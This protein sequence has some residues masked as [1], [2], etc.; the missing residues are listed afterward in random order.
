MAMLRR[1]SC[2]A[3]ALLLAAPAGA[4]DQSSQQV[5]RLLD[6]ATQSYAPKGYRPDSTSRSGALREGATERV[7]FHLSGGGI[8]SIIGVCDTSCS[9]L[10][11]VLYDAAGHVVDKDVLDD[12]APIVSWTGAS[13][14][15][16]VEVEMVKCAMSSCRYGLR[17]F[18]KP[19]GA[20]APASTAQASAS[21]KVELS[22]L[23]SRNLRVLH[24]GEQVAGTLTQ[25]SILRTDDTY[26]DGYFYDARA[27]EQITATLRSADFDSW[28]TMDQPEGQFR[29]WDDDSAG[30]R[31][32]QL[33]VTFPDAGRYLIV[34]G[35]VGKHTTGHYTLSVSRP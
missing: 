13:T 12:D 8:N 6:A 33:T 16:T 34:A 2:A 21:G 28:L 32:S 11:L 3:L 1:F 17:A 23:A 14:N 25:S 7:A 22:N 20:A 29:K 31:D 24:V 19:A 18:L 35:T 30:G 4:Q 15:L 9:N 26:M 27:G 10:D 5:T